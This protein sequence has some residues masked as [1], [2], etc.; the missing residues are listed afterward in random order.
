[1][2]LDVAGSG[3]GETVPGMD[4]SRTVGR[5][6][7]VYPAR[8]DPGSLSWS[9][10]C[11][12]GSTLSRA[13]K[14]IKEQLRAVPHDGTGFGMLRYLNPVTRGDLAAWAHHRSDSPIS[15]GPRRGPLPE[16]PGTRRISA[17]EGYRVTAGCRAASARLCLRPTW[18][19]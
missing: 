9:Q 19:S 18:W 7:C 10:V 17:T 15:A 14:Q 2:L 1:M 8:L 5:S 13:V 6:T 11:S 12:D 4:L 3:R 16:P